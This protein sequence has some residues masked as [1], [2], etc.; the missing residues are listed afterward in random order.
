MQTKAEPKESRRRW[1][2]YD[3]VKYEVV[4]ILSKHPEGLTGARIAEVVG[5][6]PGAMSKYLSMLKVDGV[7]TSRQVGV[8]KLWKIVGASDRAGILVDKLSSKAEKAD[9]KDFAMSLV[10]QDGQLLD[11]D[12][13]R[14]LAMPTTILLHLYKYAKSII[15]EEVHAFFYQWGKEYA[16][17]V[18][19]FA[20]QIAQ[21]TETTF[22]E[23]FLSLL[24]L[25]GWGRFE[26]NQIQDTTIEVR[27]LDSIWAELENESSP[28]DDFISGALSSA[29][30][31]SF[32]GEWVFVEEACKAMKASSCVFKGRHI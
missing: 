30:S 21:R 29:A 31:I 12:G 3:N 18:S 23:S 32:G 26:V 7:I 6:T 1:Q 10:E 24:K 5:L 19:N 20:T 16:R 17:E 14:V 27:W 15:G 8:A 4:N 22:L 9:F 25:K 28:V 13:R 2:D 11:P